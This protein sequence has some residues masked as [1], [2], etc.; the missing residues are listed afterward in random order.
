MLEEFKNSITQEFKMTELGLIYYYLAIKVRPDKDGIFISHEGYVKTIL[1]KFNIK[2]SNCICTLVDC[3]VK[4]S[5][6]NSESKVDTIYF[7][8]LVGSF[9]CLTCT[10]LDILYNVGLVSRFTEH[11]RASYLL[12]TKDF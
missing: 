10:R 5:K 12:T 1:D 7:K 11:S 6:Y 2:D 8:N 3:G 9:C 4:L